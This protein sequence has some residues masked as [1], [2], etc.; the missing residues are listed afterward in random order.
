MGRSDDKQE[1][2]DLLLKSSSVEVVVLHQENSAR[3]TGEIYK[4]GGSVRMTIPPNVVRA[5]NLEHRDLCD[6]SIIK[7][8][9]KR[10]LDSLFTGGEG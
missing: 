5:L 2:P 7:R 10:T 8:D 9:K 6:I 3:F 1:N 4:Q